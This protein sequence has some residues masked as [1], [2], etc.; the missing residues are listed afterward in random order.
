MHYDHLLLHQS[1]IRYMLETAAEK[2][3]L[4]LGKF[5]PDKEI[6]IDEQAG[7]QR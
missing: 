5:G 7:E 1:K 6:L 2:K 3:W 4:I